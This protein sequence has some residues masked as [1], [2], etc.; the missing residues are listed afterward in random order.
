MHS[1]WK[2][3]NQAIKNLGKTKRPI[4]PSDLVPN[5]SQKGV[6]MR[7]GLDIAWIALKRIADVLV[8]VTGDSDF[9]PAM[10]MA[11]KEGLTVVLKSMGHPVFKE[12]KVH[13]DVLL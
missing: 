13:A 4:E 1:G 8:L 10:K 2:L 5:I 6:D 11:R 9:I 3:G 12:L 7:I